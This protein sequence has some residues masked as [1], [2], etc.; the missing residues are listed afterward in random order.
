[1]IRI[2]IADDHLMFRQGIGW[3]LADEDDFEIVAEASNYA[4]VIAAVRTQALDLVVLDLSMP[5]R[6]GIE[7]IGHIRTIAPALKILV[8][9]M[10]HEEQ[11][12]ARSLRAGCNGYITKDY[13]GEQ[14]VDAIRRLAEG[15]GYI[16]PNIAERLAMEFS[17]PDAEETP[18]AR[19]SNR[20]YKIFEM[21]VE[22]KSGIQIADELSLSAKTVSTHK[23]RLLR[24]MNLNNQTELV[25]YAMDHHLLRS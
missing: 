3:L 9:T 6:D 18:H 13:A 21:L 15:R 19:L 12:A 17:R 2:L 7:M 5:G 1:M 20:E 22:G 24:K 23:A 14:L 10:H 8:L 4:E 16:C 11:Y 25:R